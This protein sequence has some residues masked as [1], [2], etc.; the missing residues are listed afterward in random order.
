VTLRDHVLVH[1][2]AIAAGTLRDLAGQIAAAP[3]T[4]S[5]VSDFE[6]EAEPGIVD[7]K[8]DTRIRD[9][10]EVQLSAETRTRLDTLLADVVARHIDPFYAVRV[11]DHEPLQVLHY[12]PGG[13]YIPHVDAET[14]FKDDAG[15]E[16]WEKSLDRDLSVVCFLNDDF[17][18]GELVFPA[19]DLVIPPR[20]GTLVCFPSDHNYIHGVNPVTRG[21]RYTLVTWLRVHGMPTMDEINDETMAEYH[22]A[23][24][25]QIGQP[26]RI[27][28]G[29]TR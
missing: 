23:F 7:W 22:R 8:V 15:L 27:V 4:D 11:R 3:M 21:H 5:L 25:Q 12:G 18:G 16:L 20:A 19:L 13:H 17:D 1:E 6:G 28:K 2:G 26:P 24:P 14:L 9:T 10:Q 29:G